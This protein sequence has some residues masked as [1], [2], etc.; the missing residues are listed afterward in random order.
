MSYAENMY[1]CLKRKGL[2][3]KYEHA[4]FTASALTISS[5]ISEKAIIC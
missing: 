4:G 3:R 2:D 5:F 1:K